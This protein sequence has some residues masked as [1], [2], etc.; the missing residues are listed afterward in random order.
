MPEIYKKKLIATELRVNVD[1]PFV[2][3]VQTNK[4]LKRRDVC[5]IPFESFKNINLALGI[6]LEQQDKR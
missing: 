2:V 5:M 1:D 3:I 6:W 4:Y